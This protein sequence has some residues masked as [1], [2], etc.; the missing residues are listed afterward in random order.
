MY[1]R[2]GM[3]MLLCCVS[4]REDTRAGCRL[5]CCGTRITVC[6]WLSIT[7]HHRLTGTC[8]ET[9]KMGDEMRANGISAFVPA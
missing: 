8:A 2:Y 6:G 1:L 3:N 7:A 5:H 9:A 4:Q